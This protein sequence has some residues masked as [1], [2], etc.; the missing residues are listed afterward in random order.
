MII[1]TFERGA[2]LTY[3]CGTGVSSSVYIAVAKKKI[4]YQAL[5]VLTDGGDIFIQVTPQN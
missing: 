1:K 5:K 3:S 2:G 4:T